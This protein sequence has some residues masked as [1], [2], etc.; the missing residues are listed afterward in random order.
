MHSVRIMVL[1]VTVSCIKVLIVAQ[2]CFRGEFLSP[3]TMKL[4][5]SCKV[6]DILSDF[7]RIWSLSTDCNVSTQCHV[8]P[9]SV[10]WEP[11]R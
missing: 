7:K 1:R 4:T 9:K 3:A 2:Q 5:S 8:S 11:R 10:Q 6:P